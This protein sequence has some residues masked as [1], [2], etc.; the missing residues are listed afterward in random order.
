MAV[1]AP[2]RS[3]A[4]PPRQDN[5]SEPTHLTATSVARLHEVRTE[6]MRGRRY[7]LDAADIIR[8]AREERA[9]P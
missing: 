9:A 3:A 1:N 4:S 7:T 8:E 5:N 2:K 6:V